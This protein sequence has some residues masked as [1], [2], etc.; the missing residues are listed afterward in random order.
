MKVN[1][2]LGPR[3]RKGSTQINEQDRPLTSAEYAQGQLGISPE[4]YQQLKQ[5]IA[6]IESGGRYDVVGGHNRAYTGKYQ[7][8]SAAIADAAAELGIRPPTRQELLADPDLQEKMQD[9]LIAKNIKYIAYN[10]RDAKSAQKFQSMTPQERAAMVAMAHSGGHGAAKSYMHRGEESY[11]AFGTPGEKYRQAAMSV[12]GDT[13]TSGTG[14]AVRSGT[15]TAVRPG[16]SLDTTPG[17][18]T[19]GI[20]LSADIPRYAG[21]AGSQ[22]LQRLNPDLIKDVNKIY[23]GDVIQTP[24]GSYKIQSGDTLDQIAQR[25]GVSGTTAAPKI[26]ES[27]QRNSTR[28]AKSRSTPGERS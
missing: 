13:V 26:S 19:P 15:G 2:I 8:G 27:L 28:R 9:A 17:A 5:N 4:Q 18:R 14:A 10:P 23:A 7:L 3:S 6:G 25:L 16:L 21:S 11:D 24:S 20:D 1:E 12:F 22:E